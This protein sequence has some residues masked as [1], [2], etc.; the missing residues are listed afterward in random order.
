[1]STPSRGIADAW[2]KRNAEMLKKHEEGCSYAKLS[3]I[4][5]MRLDSVKYIIKRERRRHNEY[6]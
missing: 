6:T 1:M 4:Y 2:K 5:G 3:L